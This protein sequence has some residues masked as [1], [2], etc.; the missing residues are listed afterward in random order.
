[1]NETAAP[2]IVMLLSNAFRPDP[3][4]LKEAESLSQKGYRITVLCWDRAA[5]LPARES[6][7][8]GTHIVRIQDVPSVYGIGMGQLTKL[9]RFWQAAWKRLSELRPD[10]I[11]CH[12]FDTLP[13]G[14]V[15][16]KLHRIPV[17]YDAHEYY[18]D[19]C[20]PRLHGA[21]GSALYHAIRLAESLGARFAQAVITVDETLA[22]LY[23]KR[24]KRVLVIGHYPQRDLAGQMNPVFQ[25]PELRMLYA[26]R[27]SRDRGLLLYADLLRQLRKLGVPARLVLAGAFTPAS[28]A[29]VLQQ[30][31]ADLEEFIDQLG[32]VPYENMPEVLRAADIGLALL[33]PEPRYVAALP[34]KLFEYMAAGLPVIASNFPLIA[35]VVTSSQCGALVD[36]RECPSAAVNVVEEWW[37]ARDLGQSLGENGRQAVLNEYNWESLVGQIDLLYQ[38]LLSGKLQSPLN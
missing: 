29:G 9:P 11:H 5:E 22:S 31:T 3:R 25:G 32:W 7:P 34:V 27:L 36:P 2:R 16:G 35:Q 37:A 12:D 13:A 33:Q 4:V 30:H 8:Q 21:R 23:R 24:N 38:S 14:L 20:K 1:M 17:V 15:W 19:L 6:L 18:A 28:E 10:L 26:G